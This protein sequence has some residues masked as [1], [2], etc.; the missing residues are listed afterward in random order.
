MIKAIGFDLDD[1]LYDRNAIYLKVFQAMQA[2]G[3]GTELHF[4]NFNPI[5][6][7]LSKAYY[8]R[9]MAGEVDKKTYQLQRTIDAYQHFGQV[10]SETLS[11]DFL[12]FYNQFKNKLDLRPHLDTLFKYLNSK[13]YK[14]F[15]LT[16]GE[17]HHQAKKI[18]ALPLQDH[19]D[20]CDIYISGDL[21]CSKPEPIIYEKVA[22]NLRLEP[23][24]IL[25]IGDDWT[26]DYRGAID[27]GW[28][29][30]YLNVRDLLPHEPQA[31]DVI[32]G[33]EEELLNYL[34]NIF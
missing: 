21:D 10:I 29:A 28:Q 30:V 22:K 9:Y 31:H 6:Q 16:N 5:Y 20:S 11:Q 17:S 12:D 33:S 2:Q 18:Q 25:Y 19:F 4:S 34:T 15:I 23:E 14:L 13:G 8:R 32:C 26:N 3:I 27:A 1:T 24:E 7:E